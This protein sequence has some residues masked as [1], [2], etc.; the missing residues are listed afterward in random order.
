MYLQG[1]DDAPWLDSSLPLLSRVDLL[2]GQMT[3]KEKLQQLL[4]THLYEEDTSSFL[5]KYGSSGFG[6]LLPCPRV[7]NSSKHYQPSAA[8]CM[9]WRNYIQSH[10]L[11]KS[12]LRLPVSFREEVLHS[13]GIPGATVFP[14]PANLGASWNRTLV[15]AV[16]AIISREA[17]AGG[18]DYGFGP[19]LQ[20]ATNALWGRNQE[21]FGADPFLVTH[22][23]EAATRGLQG[24]MTQDGGN[25]V[26]DIPHFLPFHS[27]DNL[28]YHL[29]FLKSSTSRKA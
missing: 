2:V 1:M 22:L 7:R 15:T 16:Y 20:V 18:V 11:N 13:A 6:V 23:V 26:Y 9:Q 27:L 24:K 28:F 8:Q 19:V 12:R 5:S 10:L 14:M 21:A 25:G 4:S 3:E 29:I 17:R